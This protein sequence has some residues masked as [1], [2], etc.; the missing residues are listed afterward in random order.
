[1]VPPWSFVSAWLGSSSWA[2]S[3]KATQLHIKLWRICQML[4]A[5]SG[6]SAAKL[7]QTLCD[8]FDYRCQAPL[9]STVSQCQAPLSST[10]SQ[11]LLK[12]KSIESVMLSNHLILCCPL[13]L[14]SI[15]PSIRVCSWLSLSGGQSIGASALVTVPPVNI[16][17]WFPLGFTGLISVQSKG[18]SKVFSSTTI[19]KHQFFSTQLCLCS[20]SD[21]HTWLLG[22]QRFDYMDLCWPSDVS[23]F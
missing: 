18:L 21:I 12:F 9:S 10:V 16:H 14:P 11:S 15:F 7:C 8:P 5:I 23:D 4:S 17:S 19:W 22:K 6:C 20:N 3:P 13:L 2:S 1:M